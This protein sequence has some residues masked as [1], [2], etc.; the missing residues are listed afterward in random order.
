[1]VVATAGWVLAL[2]EL[3]AMKSLELL[4]DQKILILDHRPLMLHGLGYLLRELQQQH[5][6]Q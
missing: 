1:V 4:L 5:L 3:D 6:L 2:V